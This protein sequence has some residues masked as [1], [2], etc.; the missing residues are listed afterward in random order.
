MNQTKI[1]GEWFSAQEKGYKVRNSLNDEKLE[2]DNIPKGLAAWQPL[3]VQYAKDQT[4]IPYNTSL[5]LMFDT[6]CKADPEDEDL[7]KMTFGFDKLIL[8]NE[9]ERHHFFIQLFRIMHLA[10]NLDQEGLSMLK[11]MQIAYNIGQFKAAH[12]Q[13]A[14]PKELIEFFDTN[15]LGEISTYVV[16]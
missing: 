7:N 8:S 2:S 4:K 16:L 1:T 11:L 10:Y 13:K 5:L 6:Y 14:Y 3:K 15:K 12:Q 9:V